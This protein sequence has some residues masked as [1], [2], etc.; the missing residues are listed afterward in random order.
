MPVFVA[1]IALRHRPSDPI[2]VFK[3]EVVSILGHL[4]H[5]YFGK[6]G[7]ITQDQTKRPETLLIDHAHARGWQADSRSRRALRTR[8]PS[9]PLGL[10]P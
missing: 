4:D 6:T 8:R 9:L 7:L 10:I 5:F 3:L 2:S 1:Y